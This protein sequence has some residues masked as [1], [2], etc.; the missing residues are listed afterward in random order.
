M[1]SD[2]VK[3]GVDR[4]PHRSLFKAMGYTDNELARPL[5]AVV[6]AANEI[7]PGH[8]HLDKIAK[9]VADGI[10]SAGGT[11][12]LLPTI[13]VCDGIAM[14][15]IGMKYSLASR[16]LIA[17]SVETMIMGHAFDAVA[18]VPNCDKIVPGMLM[19][20]ARLNR[21]SIFVSG[22]PMLPGKDLKGKDNSLSQ[23]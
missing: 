1:I 13:G 2:S 16:E 17:D 18:Y 23:V 6:H 5:V 7:I 8:I 14:G 20:A 4:A 19:G 22:G 15:H 11:P 12:V 9:A 10:R 21:P 3:K